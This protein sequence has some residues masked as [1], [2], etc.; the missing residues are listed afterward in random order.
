[1]R[2]PPPPDDPPPAEAEAVPDGEK[3]I[4][5]SEP[6]CMSPATLSELSMVLLLLAEALF[7]GLELVVILE[8]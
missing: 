6:A 2:T 4:P 5:G 7:L 1:V 8:V 3:S